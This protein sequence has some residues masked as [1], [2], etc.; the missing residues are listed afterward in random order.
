MRSAEEVRAKFEDMRSKRLAQRREKFLS[1]T[2]RNCLHNVRLRVKGSGKC[3]FCRNPKVV[4][5]APGEP[6]V[7]DEEG[8]ARRCKVFE[9][10]NTPQ[11]VAEDFEEVL[12]S[13]AR[14]GL[15][16]PKL[17]IMIWFLQDKT[18]RS[19]PQRFATASAELARALFALL[20][21]R[22]W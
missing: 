13:P 3:G 7:C 11:T 12:R 21:W 20:P 8:T 1:R 17:A 16:Y 5:R 14:C 4:G 2:H 19:R 15:E 9:C 18:R 22:W 10:R 6:F